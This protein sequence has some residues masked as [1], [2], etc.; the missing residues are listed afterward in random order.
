MPFPESKRN[1]A[2]LKQHPEN[3]NRNGR[4]RKMVSDII[5]SLEK[6]GVKRVSKEQVK[7]AFELLLNLSEDQIKELVTDKEK[8]MLLRIVAKAMVSGKGFDII[9]KMIDRTHGKAIQTTDLISD[10]E[11]I[12]FDVRVPGIRKP[13]DE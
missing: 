4:P 11:R 3:I 6:E 7:G 2:G 1:I 8:P 10:G 5:D 13:K 9:E 12:V